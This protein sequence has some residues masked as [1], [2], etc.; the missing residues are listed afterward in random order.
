M[1]V[2]NYKIAE[3]KRNYINVPKNDFEHFEKYAK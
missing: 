2:K 1:Q 3:R